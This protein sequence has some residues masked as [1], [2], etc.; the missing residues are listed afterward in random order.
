MGL[1]ACIGVCA[2][3]SSMQF[4][5][6][7]LNRLLAASVVESAYASFFMYHS[8]ANTLFEW[9]DARMWGMMSP[10]QSDLCR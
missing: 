4:L 2:R 7:Y 3:F 10:S 8:V 1:P 5:E 9:D 6:R